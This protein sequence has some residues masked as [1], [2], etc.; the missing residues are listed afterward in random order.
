ML[1]S[2]HIKLNIN[3]WLCTVS[4]KTTK[5][6]KHCCQLMICIVLH[7]DLLV[8]PC[9]RKSGDDWKIRCNRA[10]LRFWCKTRFCW[11]KQLF[12][13]CLS[14]LHCALATLRADQ[15]LNSSCPFLVIYYRQMVLVD[16]RNVNITE[17]FTLQCLGSWT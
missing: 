9:T 5:Q 1:K 15:R 4:K 3:K 8:F 6:K 11:L 12:H 16:V 17:M 7:A 13:L 14:L 2:L 10:S